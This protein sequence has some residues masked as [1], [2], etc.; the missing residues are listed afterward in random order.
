MKILATFDGSVFSESIIPQLRVLSAIPGAEFILLRV[1]EVPHGQATGVAD[2]PVPA[3]PASAGGTAMVTRPGV[4]SVIETKEQAVERVKAESADYL[5]SVATQL[6]SSVPCAIETAMD[7]DVKS[8]IVKCAMERQVDLIVMATHGRTGVVHVICG[9]V[10][11]SVLRS[12]VAPVL[13]VHPH[14]VARSRQD[15]SGPAKRLR[16]S[17]AG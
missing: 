17:T 9:D 10:A 1:D 16:R 14:E 7:N 5:R 8:S 6:P 12:G 11:E 15:Q 13:L 4:P 3:T 2:P